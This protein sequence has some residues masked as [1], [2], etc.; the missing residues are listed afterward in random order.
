MEQISNNV[1]VLNV[2]DQI[3]PGTED[4]LKIYLGGSMDLGPT[5]EYNW[6]QKFIDGMKVAVDPTKG[7]MNLFSKYNYIIFN[8]YYVPKNPAQNIFNQEFTQKWT[9]E[10]QCLEMAD[11]IFLNFL[12]KSTSPLP[13]YTFGYIVR[14]GKLVVRCP[15][16][17]TNYGIVKMACD[18]YNVPLVGSKMGTVNQILSLMFSFIPKFQEVGKNT[19]PEKKK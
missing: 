5:G 12:G 1:M 4:A 7:Y 11:C 8:P 6:F 19:L 15:E 13:L 2:G 17:Y 18:T 3:P 9:W 10:N 16:I 14:S